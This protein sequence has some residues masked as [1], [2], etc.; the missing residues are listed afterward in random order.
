[1]SGRATMQQVAAR[2]GVSLKTVS[3]VVNDEP[4]VSEPLAVRVRDAVAEL[5]YRHNLAASNLRR[6][7]RSASIGVLVDDLANDYCGELLRAVEARARERGM[8]VVAASL[9]EDPERE[10]ALVESLLTRRVDGLVLMPASRDQGYLEREARAGLPVVVVDR[11]P[12]GVELDSVTSDNR[13]GS[14]LAVHHLARHGHRRIAMIGD[15][16][17]IV[18]AAERCRGYREALDELGIPLDHDLI[19]TGV[20][21]TEDARATTHRLMSLEDP[22]TAVFAARNVLTVGV[23]RALQELGL[24]DSV[25]VVGFDDFPTADLLRP[26]VTCVKQDVQAAGILAIDLLLAR[27]DGDPAPTRTEVLPTRLVARG[28]GEIPGP[29]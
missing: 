17:S 23:V 4:G 25:A 2:A 5:G 8:A 1:M 14:A 16:L 26:G 19:L 28:S 15:D 6:G 13:D 11:S 18:T 7:H 27:V 9:D 22:P 20:R 21:T 12:Q 29:G 10:H 24:V 3:R